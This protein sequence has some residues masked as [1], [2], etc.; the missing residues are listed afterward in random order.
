MAAHDTVL[1][2]AVQ[3]FGNSWSTT[4]LDWVANGL[5]IA[6]GAILIIHAIRKMSIKSAIGGAVGLVIC[7]SIFA[8]RF[9]ISDMFQTEYKDPGKN[10]VQI[11]G[12]PNIGAPPLPT[13]AFQGRL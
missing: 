10:S 3:N 4:L 7:W 2:G 11:P 13:V 5:M 12:D 9:V 1:A 8:G 6:L